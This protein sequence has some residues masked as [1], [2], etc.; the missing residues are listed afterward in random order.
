MAVSPGLKYLTLRYNSAEAGGA[1]SMSVDYGGVPGTQ[2][3]TIGL[4][5]GHHCFSAFFLKAMPTMTL[6]NLP[7]SVMSPL[8]VVKRLTFSVGAI[9]TRQRVAAAGS[10]R[11]DS[12]GNETAEAFD[13]KGCLGQLR[14]QAGCNA[15]ERR[16]GLETNDVGA[17]PT[18][19]RGRPMSQL[20][21]ERLKLRSHRGNGD[22]MSAQGNVEQHEKP[23]RWRRVTVNRTSARNRPGRVGWR[24]GP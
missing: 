7:I 22:S 3:L 9:P 23:Q 16:A 20:H 12:G 2:Y 19:G 18:M 4:K 11:S 8:C 13:G 5:R 14:E 1:A 15:S 17:D 10:N 6:P 24:R 21:V